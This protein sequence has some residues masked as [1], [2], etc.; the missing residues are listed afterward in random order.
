MSGSALAHKAMTFGEQFKEPEIPE[1]EPLKDYM[2]VTKSIHEGQGKVVFSMTPGLMSQMLTYYE[3]EDVHKASDNV[4]KSLCMF[5]TSDTQD[6]LMERAEERRAGSARLVAD[7]GDDVRIDSDELGL[8]IVKRFAPD[9]HE[10]DELCDPRYA[11]VDFELHLL[12]EL[13]GTDPYQSASKLILRR[14]LQPERYV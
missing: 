4:L 11:A 5:A 6:E 8:D 10:L 2:A 9:T 7:C 14:L 3:V 12:D 1:S 13:R